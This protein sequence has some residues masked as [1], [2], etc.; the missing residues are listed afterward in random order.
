MRG[1]RGD[2]TG[3]RPVQPAARR[4][5]GRK[6]SENEAKQ[7]ELNNESESERRSLATRSGP[8]RRDL[9]VSVSSEILGCFLKIFTVLQ[10]RSSR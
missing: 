5:Y 6:L 7:R 4:C 2:V 9:P 10:C 1:L 8:Q 3:K